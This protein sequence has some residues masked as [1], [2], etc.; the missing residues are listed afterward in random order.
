MLIF[1]LASSSQTFERVPGV[2]ARKTESCLAMSIGGGGKFKNSKSVQWETLRLRRRKSETYEKGMQIS[3]GVHSRNA[4]GRCWFLRGIEVVPQSQ[5][6]RA[7]QHIVFTQFAGIYLGVGENLQV[8]PHDLNGWHQ[9]RVPCA[10]APASACHDD[11][12]Q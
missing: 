11:I 8:I 1:C 5:Q 2:L 6:D 10:K 7:S 12:R 9:K 3:S 4:G